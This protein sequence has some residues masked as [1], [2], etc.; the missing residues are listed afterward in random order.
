MK[1]LLSLA[2]I[3]TLLLGVA[4]YVHRYT[5]EKSKPKHTNQT[6]N[7]SNLQE[8]TNDDRYYEVIL[9]TGTYYGKIDKYSSIDWRLVSIYVLDGSTLM[10]YSEYLR[11]RPRE[12][13][14]STVQT[15]QSLDFNPSET[16]SIRQLTPDDKVLALITKIAEENQQNYVKELTSNTE[17]SN[18]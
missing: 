8:P 14:I 16:K 9:S 4:Y 13:G 2:I 12:S 11:T 5:Q 17:G 7:I 3:I 1:R 6:A 18:Q 15:N 10:P